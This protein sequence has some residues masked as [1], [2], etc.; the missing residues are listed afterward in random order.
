[1]NRG[2]LAVA[3]ALGLTGCA[4]REPLPVYGHVPQFSLI[5]ENG[6]A[7]D[8]R[9]LDGKVWVA[10]F[11]FTTCP[12]PC[13]RMSSQMHWVEKQVASLP[14]VSLVSFTVDPERD[15]PLVLAAY[16]ERL[17]A[18]TGRWHFLTGSQAELNTLDR[19][20]FHLGTVDGTLMHA[21]LFALV[22]GQR[23]IRGYYRTEEGESLGPLI[24]GIRR[25]VREGS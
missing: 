4:R 1:V 16:A 24:T 10:D 18:D 15:T 23:R 14:G 22:D 21:T 25:L 9:T 7:F 6:R 12:G 13:P 5:S 20:A 17:R 19:D 8:S 2:L 11:F 3:L